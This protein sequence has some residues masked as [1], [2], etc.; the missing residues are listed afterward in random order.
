[1]GHSLTVSFNDTL[2][3]SALPFR[4][5]VALNAEC[6]CAFVTRLPY[7]NNDRNENK[8][9]VIVSRYTLSLFIPPMSTEGN[10][11]IQIKNK[12]MPDNHVS[13]SE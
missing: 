10:H 13:D 1:M 7:L 12:I 9:S 2:H 6:R 8:L 3:N 5:G 11:L 4:L